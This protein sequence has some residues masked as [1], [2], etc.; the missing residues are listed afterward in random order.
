MVSD[1]L[2]GMCLDTCVLADLILH[3]EVFCLQS[4]L[5]GN[6]LDSIK[7]L[8]QFSQFHLI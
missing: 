2:S 4:K 7:R 3:L 6:R 1:N 8:I 5:L